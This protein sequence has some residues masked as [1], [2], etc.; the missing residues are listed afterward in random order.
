[1]EWANLVEADSSLER[2]PS[3]LKPL[4]TLCQKPD[5]GLKILGLRTNKETVAHFV[6]Q[7]LKFSE[8]SQMTHIVRESPRNRLNQCDNTLLDSAPK[9]SFWPL[10][11]AAPGLCRAVGVRDDAIMNER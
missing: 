9:L 7:N 5:S 4:V 6:C 8:R 10:A 2:L 1:V 3:C 11:I